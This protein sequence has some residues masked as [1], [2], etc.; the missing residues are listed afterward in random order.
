[1][2]ILYDPTL[3]GPLPQHEKSR[4]LAHLTTLLPDLTL[5]HREEDLHPF[6]CDGL[7]AYRVMPM[8]V[9]LPERVEQVA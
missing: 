5:L 9:A 2:N 7:A 4:V 8:L 1:M 6:E 3:D